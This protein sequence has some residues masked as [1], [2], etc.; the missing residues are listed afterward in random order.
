VLKQHHLVPEKFASPRVGE[1]K[2]EHGFGIP[3]V[4]VPH[5]LTPNLDRLT[6][7]Q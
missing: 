7:E 2:T 5:L 6:Y 1:N 3:T 4:L